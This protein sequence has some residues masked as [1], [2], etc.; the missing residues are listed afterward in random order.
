MVFS[1]RCCQCNV[2][3]TIDMF[4]TNS[5][6][7]KSSRLLTF[8]RLFAV[9]PS[10]GMIR[11]C[12]LYNKSNTCVCFDVVCTRF[13]KMI[14]IRLSC[15]MMSESDVSPW[16]TTEWVIFHPKGKGTGLKPSWRSINAK[17]FDSHEVLENNMEAQESKKTNHMSCGW[18]K[19]L[20]WFANSGVW[21]SHCWFSTLLCYIYCFIVNSGWFCPNFDYIVKEFTSFRFEWEI[22]RNERRISTS[23]YVSLHFHEF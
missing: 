8:R 18:L 21:P 22:L 15:T 4:R 10:S 16:A 19:F 12:Q 5:L 7:Q 17:T 1:V 11:Q 9:R 14:L 23:G 13:K 20:P 6:A 3:G 2:D